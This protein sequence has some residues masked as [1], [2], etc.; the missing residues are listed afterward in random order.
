[1]NLKGGDILVCKGHSAISK[2]ILFVTKGKWSH[3]ALFATVW[4]ISGVI[5]AQA[6]GVNWKQLEIWAD[7][8]K[9]EYVVFRHCSAFDEKEL[10]TKAFSKC[11]ET[12]YDFWTFLFRIPKKIITGKWKDRGEKEDDKMICSEFTGWVWGIPNNES[13]TP[14]QQFDY[15]R[16]SS[17]WVTIPQLLKG[18]I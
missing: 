4:G 10:L 3:T 15:L 16:K 1:M 12:K 7:K 8:W 9:Y 6:N 13:M 11:G 17:D 5:E 14:Q 2:G 18:E